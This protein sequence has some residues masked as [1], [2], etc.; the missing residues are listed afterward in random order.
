MDDSTKSIKGV[1]QDRR[2][3]KQLQ[4]GRREFPGGKSQVVRPHKTPD[5][6]TV[7]GTPAGMEHT[8]A[9]TRHYLHPEAVAHRARERSGGK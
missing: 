8:S 4:L 2:E 3:G 9:R 5:G 1:S 6:Q 7:E